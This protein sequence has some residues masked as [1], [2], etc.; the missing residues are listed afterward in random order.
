MLSRSALNSNTELFDF[1]PGSANDSKAFGH[2]SITSDQSSSISM[3]KSNSQMSLRSWLRDL[4]R[5]KGIE[6]DFSAVLNDEKLNEFRKLPIARTIC[7]KAGLQMYAPDSP[8]PE[9]HSKP[10]VG[11]MLNALPVYS[12][13][14][15]SRKQLQKKFPGSQMF[16]DILIE[17]NARQNGLLS[18][19]AYHGGD[20]ERQKLQK[21]FPDDKMYV[22]ILLEQKMSKQAQDPKLQLIRE[23]VTSELKHSGTNIHTL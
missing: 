6:G 13:G 2:K 12:D 19:S 20:F 5:S 23:R 14:E 21:C 4:L 11:S 10:R 3:P 22:D 9:A 1:I 17:K 7:K 8:Y 18:T 15:D 16:I